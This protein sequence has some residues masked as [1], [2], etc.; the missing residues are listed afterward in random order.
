MS[1][2]RLGPSG[3]VTPEAVLDHL[4]PGAD[5]I[6]PLANGEPVSVLD[7]IEAANESLRGV[8][9]HQMHALHDRRYLHGDFGDRLRHVSYFLSHITRPHFLSG[10]LD[11][12]PNN[13]SEMRLILQEATTD[14]LVI[15]AASPP[16]RHGYFSLGVS[17]DYVSSL[18]GRARFFLEANDRMPRTFGRNQIHISQ[19]VGYCESDR[20]LIEVPP[21][22]MTPADEAI[23]N[24]VAE[25]IPHRATIQTGIGSIP[26]AIMSALRDHQDLGVH[27]ELLSD[28]VI[29]LIEAGVV[30][31]VA[32]T[33]NRTKTIG[34]FALGTER[35]YDFLHDNAAVELWPVRYVNDPRVIA[36]LDNFVSV[37]AT[38]A[39]DFLGQ[40]A[41]E[42]I[43][44]KYFSSSGGQADFARGALYSHGG[45]GFITLHSTTAQGA[46]SKIVPRL[47]P[48]DV[49]T[50]IKN[51]VDHVVT[52]HGIA[53][54]RGR[55][56]RDR[57][58][59]LIDIAD[60]AHRDALRFEA[61]QMGY[62]R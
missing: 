61:T 2:R 41:S 21:P 24:L 57:T 5:I 56:I 45:Q 14:P 27:T 47:A 29:D 23:A 22:P 26:N 3:P 49:V 32:K 39:V 51:T 37:N 10:A 60:P 52:E 55:S 54:L 4:S 18:I 6:V 19:I 17:A 46:I 62:L 44:G 30:N 58:R 53:K 16:D 43:N 1:E 7:A 31:G 35:L 8:R 11:L 48:G 25:R 50:T 34:T 9:V 38:V 36:Q 13:F 40:C 59:A 15:A 33:I 12:V 42:T 28:G 20:R